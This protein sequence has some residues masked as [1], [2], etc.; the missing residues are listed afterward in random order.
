MTFEGK[1]NTRYKYCNLM[2]LK[3]IDSDGKIYDKVPE[4]KNF[5]EFYLYPNEIKEN[6]QIKWTLCKAEENF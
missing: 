2:T 4:G 5:N 1:P 6:T 3:Y